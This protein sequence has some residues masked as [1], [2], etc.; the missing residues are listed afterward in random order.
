MA[1]SPLAGSEGVVRV[2]VLCNGQPVPDIVE[3]LAVRLKRMVNAIPWARIELVDGDMPNQAFPLS[4]A[5]TFVPGAEVEI[6]AGYGDQESTL[7]KGLVIRH[8]IRV[9]A[10]N[11]ARLVIE[12]RDK[13]VKLTVGR[14]N[15][16]FIDKKDSDIISALISG[17]GLSANV[18]Q[19][20]LQH[21]ELVQ[22]HCTD[23]DFLLSRAEAN[24]L[25]VIPVDGT[26]SV[27]APAVSGSAVLCVTYGESLMDL[28]TEMDA[29]SQLSSVSA[30]AW[31]PKTQVSKTGSAAA[32]RT[33][34]AQGNLS[35]GDL[36]KVIG[37]SEYRLQSMAALEAEELP[38]WAKARQLKAGLA[39]VRGRMRFQGSALALPGTLI[40][41]A[42]VGERYNG[43]VF[44]TSVEHLIED[45]EWITEVGFGMGDQWFAD[46]P[47][48]S[49]PLAAGRLP[50]VQ[51]L[52]VGVVLKLDGDPAGESRIKVSVPVMGAEQDGVWARL[53]QLYAS[54]A[55][56]ALFIP[57]VGDEV[58]LG[59]FDADPAHP[60]VL[61]SLYSSSK[62][63]PPYAFAADNNTKAV[64]TRTKLKIEFDEEKKV[65]TIQTPAVNKIVLSDDGKSILLED[66]NGNTARLD[67]SGIALDSPKDIRITAKGGITLDAVNAIQIT[68]KADVKA[69]GLNVNCDAQV[70][71]AAKGAATAE[72]SASGQTTVKGALVMIN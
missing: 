48:V 37:L 16:N 41:L 26:V 9:G 49:N 59:F 42:G 45:G 69:S 14:K 1:V 35:S 58:V 47:E 20:T 29:R 34:N 38:A 66:Q 44:V 51:G 12:C 50:G 65:I 18:G 55:F 10:D 24:G 8:G 31:D 63:P 61:G 28:E 52:H 17:A 19:T 7:F 60:V 25:L 64:V 6:K 22:Y 68:A 30:Y 33:L 67:Q 15:A 21:G 53:A 62:H 43:D 46:R 70:G 40:E 36:A 71:F 27:K 57:E 23:W 72:L 2:T 4:D 32:P 13:A 39:R 56:G 11:D 5:E 54:N 3:V